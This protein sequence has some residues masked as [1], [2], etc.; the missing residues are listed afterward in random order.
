MHLSFIYLG[1]GLR[2]YRKCRFLD[3]SRER[4]YI[5]KRLRH[6]DS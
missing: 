3:S 4:L 1:K 5:E 2:V 6:R